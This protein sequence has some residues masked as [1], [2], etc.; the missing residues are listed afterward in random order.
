MKDLTILYYTANINKEPF[1]AN[2]QRQ[3]LAA[4]GD[5]PIVSV[6]FKP[7][8][9]PGHEHE[10]I[11]IG[12][13]KR[14]NYMLYSQ[15]LMAAKAAKTEF[16]ATAEDDMLYSPTHFTFRPQGNE[17][18]YNINKWS[19][20]SWTKPPVFSY[21]PRRLMNSL[22]VRRDALVENLTNRYTKYPVH[23]EVP[24]RIMDFYWGEPGRFE[25]HLGIPT[26][27]TMEFNSVEPNI[28]F[29]T[30]EALGFQSLGKRKAHSK[31]LSEFVAPWGTAEQV[32][33][34]YHE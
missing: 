4:I 34:Y 8:A 33:K 5:A 2:T 15:V 16:V 30:E 11:C 31:I 25:N 23:A 9:F 6:S 12:E 17:F 13:Q 18:A 29:S 28:M 7:V 21:R 20:F 22:I 14:S 19:I 27:K 10:N 3:L 1:M 32:L 26:V 24:Q